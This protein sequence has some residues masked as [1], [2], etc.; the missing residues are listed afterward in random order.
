MKEKPRDPKEGILTKNFLLQLLWYG[1]LIAVS[2]VEESS[3]AWML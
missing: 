1:G 3:L 2:M